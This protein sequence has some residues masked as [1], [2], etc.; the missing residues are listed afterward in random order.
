MAQPQT[1]ILPLFGAVPSF[2]TCQLWQSLCHLFQKALH[3]FPL[4]PF[5]F[6][7]RLDWS[8]APKKPLGNGTI[9]FILL[10]SSGRQ[11]VVKLVLC[12]PLNIKSMGDYEALIGALERRYHQGSKVRPHIAIQLYQLGEWDTTR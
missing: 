2:F 1:R 11:Q 10:A 4:L 7:L 12:N 3:A 9:I 5:Q 8:L 6:L